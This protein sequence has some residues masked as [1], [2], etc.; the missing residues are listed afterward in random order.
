LNCYRI[1]H[2]GKF[3][4]FLSILVGLST[5]AWSQS[6]LES[7]GERLYL[8]NLLDLEL[9]QLKNISQNQKAYSQSE[10]GSENYWIERTQK[11]LERRELRRSQEDMGRAHRRAAVSPLTGL[12]GSGVLN[13]ATPYFAGKAYQE[14][15]LIDLENYLAEARSG[16]FYQDYKGESLDFKIRWMRDS[17]RG[18]VDEKIKATVTCDGSF[19]LKTLFQFRRSQIHSGASH[20]LSGRLYPDQ[21]LANF[22]LRLGPET[23]DC[24]IKMP[25]RNKIYEVFLKPESHAFKSMGTPFH[26]VELCDRLPS[27]GKEFFRSCRQPL[28]EIEIITDPLQALAK[29][30]E[31]LLGKELSDEELLSYRPGHPIDFSKA[32]QLQGIFISTLF[33]EYDLTGFLILELLRWHA[34]RGTPVWILSSKAGLHKKNKLALEAFADRLPN[35]QVKFFQA[36]GAP[37]N[38][39]FKKDLASLH[40]VD[41]VKIFATLSEGSEGRVIMGGRNI[42]DRYHF[43]QI[44]QLPKNF[45]NYGQDKADVF[46][47]DL[48][49]AISDRRFVETLARQFFK[50]W[51]HRSSPFFVAPSSLSVEGSAGGGWT[52]SDSFMEHLMSYPQFD[53][54]ALENTFLQNINAAQKTISIVTPYYQ[55]T[56]KILKALLA[57]ED[58]GVEIRV[59]TNAHYFEE[60]IAE[61]L[62]RAANL[63]VVNKT[64]QRF[65]IWSYNVPGRFLHSKIYVFDGETSILGSTNLNQRSFNYDPEHALIVRSHDL[66]I[67]LLQQVEVYREQSQLIEERVRSS[68]FFEKL[69]KPFRTEF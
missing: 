45:I 44:P 5:F 20:R 25:L 49:F 16:F 3:A 22:I 19:K 7:Q 43:L 37:G 29:K 53:G 50:F 14:V 54:R 65:Q 57:A 4:L 30:V 67:Q 11:K 47:E 31:M 26:G 56:Q 61:D 2:C 39:G 60:G 46:Y 69:F 23:R 59:V 63:Y 48:D 41:H 32:P 66:A 10:T 64:F 13:L 38:D 35:V 51:G 9:A 28:P 34:E 68:P 17:P 1:H 62:I 27:R 36:T 6:P 40:T 58:R 42:S 24:Q 8:R 18:T 33:F 21:D 52:S 12:A 55:P 15:K